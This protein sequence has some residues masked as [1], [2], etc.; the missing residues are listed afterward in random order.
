MLECC[1]THAAEQASL[2]CIRQLVKGI[3]A[4]RTYTMYVRLYY[5][6]EGVASVPA[7]AAYS[8]AER[9]LH[10]SKSAAFLPKPELPQQADVQQKDLPIGS[11][12]QDT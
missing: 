6:D 4:C 7:P 8:E 3:G 11:V 9:L 1:A 2:L 10:L 5:S 12:L